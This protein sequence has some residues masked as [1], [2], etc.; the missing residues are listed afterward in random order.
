[1]NEKEQLRNLK[2]EYFDMDVPKEGLDRMRESIDRAKMDKRR[3]QRNRRLRNAGVGVAAALAIAVALPNM[4]AN[5]AYAM[6]NLPVIGGFFRVV[7]FRDYRY[8]DSNNSAEV[9]APQVSV[10]ASGS[11]AVDQKLQ[12]SVNQ[13][14]L[15]IEKLTQDLIREFEKTVAGSEGEGHMGLYV[16]H[17]VITDNDRWFTLKLTMEEVQAS[18]Y[19]HEK[20]YT[21]DKQTGETVGL[22][23]LF[24]QGSDYVTV[25]SENIKEQMRARMKADEEKVYFLDGDEPIDEFERITGNENFYFNKDGNLT[26]VFDEYEV[27]PGYMGVQEFVISADSIA[28]I[29]K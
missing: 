10:E 28:G 13:I 20:Y 15:D 6:E 4:N 11:G 17:E 22:S 2:R 8:E 18:G 25:L 21:V 5:I 19:V 1:M 26:V 23:D 3:M 9:K 7:T 12:D 14:N 24:R 29:V 27:A 16:N